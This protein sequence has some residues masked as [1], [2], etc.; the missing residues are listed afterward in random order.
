MSRQATLLDGYLHDTA[1]VLPT[2]SRAVM[3]QF[4][5]TSLRR[6]LRLTTT[7]INRS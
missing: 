6:P 3:Q 4:A 1:I 7:P 5:L 2:E